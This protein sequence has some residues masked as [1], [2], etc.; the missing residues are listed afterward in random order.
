MKST[1]KQA[2]PIIKEL[3]FEHT[4]ESPDNLD[5][6][7]EEPE[8][9]VIYRTLNW[10]KFNSSVFEFKTYNSSEIR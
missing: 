9:K 1:N 7:L 4:L 8:K 3:K 5:N 6:F 10:N 2:P